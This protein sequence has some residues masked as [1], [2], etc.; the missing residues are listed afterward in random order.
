MFRL[1]GLF[2]LVLGA[3]AAVIEEEENVIVLTK[4]CLITLIF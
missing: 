2:F 3:S 1:V 4:V